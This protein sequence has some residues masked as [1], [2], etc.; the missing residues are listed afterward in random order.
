M[1]LLFD[2]CVS[3][4]FKAG[5]TTHGHECFT[6]PEVGL[7]G[8]KNGELL[9]LAEGKFDVFVTIDKNI[10]YQQNLSGRK[11]AVL[12]VRARS[13]EI[14]DLLRELPACIVALQ[15]IGPGQLVQIGFE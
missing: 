12:I 1:K 8:R 3:R 9:T 13:S 6:V 2:E 15:S 4:L 5:F 11:I 7:A 10:R 14:D